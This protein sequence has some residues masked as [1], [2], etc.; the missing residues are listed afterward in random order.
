MDN[1]SQNLREFIKTRSFFRREVHP[2]SKDTKNA[3]NTRRAALLKLRQVKPSAR[4]RLSQAASQMPDKALAKKLPDVAFPSDVQ[5]S[6]KAAQAFRT[7]INRRL[8]KEKAYGEQIKLIEKYLA[9]EGLTLNDISAKNLL[10]FFPNIQKVLAT[11]RL[12]KQRKQDVLTRRLVGRKSRQ[13]TKDT[14]KYIERSQAT[15]RARKAA[16][17]PFKKYASSWQGIT[18]LRSE[19]ITVELESIFKDK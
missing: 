17:V 16:K 7:V 9:L 6:P 8:G 13:S 2:T 4:K 18:D 1:I 15:I 5:T 10:E 14:R 11:R 3:Y 19:N 12:A